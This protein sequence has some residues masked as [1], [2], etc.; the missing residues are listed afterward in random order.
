MT[1]ALVLTFLRQARPACFPIKLEAAVGFALDMIAAALI[2]L[3]RGEQQMI[4]INAVLF[5]LP[6]SA[7]YGPFVL[8]PF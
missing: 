8:E 3:R 4:R 2:H 5:L 1:S 7:S 6:A